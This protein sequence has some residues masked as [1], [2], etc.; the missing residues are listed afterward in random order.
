MPKAVIC[1]NNTDIQKALS[2]YLKS[3][4]FECLTPSGIEEA[5]SMSNLEDVSLVV[6]NE[7]YSKLINEISSLPMYR[8]RDIIL[9]LINSSIPTMDRLSAFALGVNAIINIKDLN[10]FPAFFKRTYNE[11]QK[12]YKIFRELLVK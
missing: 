5:I 11:Y 7:E 12:N 2:D 4:G 1:E 8:R 3:V 6:V 9:I 10:N